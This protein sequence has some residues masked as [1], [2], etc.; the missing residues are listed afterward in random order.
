MLHGQMVRQGLDEASLKLR[1]AYHEVVRG[2]ALDDD[3]LSVRRGV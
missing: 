2:E 1:P 3:D